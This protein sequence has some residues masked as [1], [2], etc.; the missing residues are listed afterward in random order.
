MPLSRPGYP[1]TCFVDQAGL[2]LR[3]LIASA[4][5]VLGLEVYDTTP[6]HFHFL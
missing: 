1:G 6:G 4:L 5:R 2:E 3:N